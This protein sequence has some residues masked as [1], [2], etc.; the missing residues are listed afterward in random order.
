MVPAQRGR[1]DR[2]LWFFVAAMAAAELYNVVAP[3]P[4]SP[5]ELAV[6]ALAAYLVLAMLAGLVDR[7]RGTS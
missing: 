4:A 7:A 3:P 5:Q 1:G 6:S 2:W